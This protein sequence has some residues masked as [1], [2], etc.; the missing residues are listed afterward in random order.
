MKN[1]DLTAAAEAAGTRDGNKK[2]L[3]CSPFVCTFEYGADLEEY[4][5][6]N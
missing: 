6:Y 1:V 3:E 5:N 2:P 4:W